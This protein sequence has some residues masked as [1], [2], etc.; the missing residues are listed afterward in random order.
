[1]FSVYNSVMRKG[2]VNSKTIS[3]R[4]PMQ[5]Y[6]E[7]LQRATNM[8]LSV[9]EYVCLKLF[10]TN[11]NIEAHDVDTPVSNDYTE[12]VFIESFSNKYDYKHKQFSYYQ[13]RS[14][15][16]FD[17]PVY[18]KNGEWMIKTIKNGLHKVYKR[19]IM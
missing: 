18:S 7:L 1:M 5:Q 12:W 19:N 2:D 14:K 15:L 16:R 13:I 6:I 17:N 4:L 9:S 8:K 11:D 3:V 10:S